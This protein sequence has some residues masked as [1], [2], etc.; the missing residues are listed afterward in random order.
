MLRNRT[1][2]FK[3]YILSE[4]VEKVWPQIECGAINRIPYYA[5]HY[6]ATKAFIVADVNTFTGWTAQIIQHEIDHCD[7]ILI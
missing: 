3:A 1:P 6:K 4:L 7:G 5:A 2:E